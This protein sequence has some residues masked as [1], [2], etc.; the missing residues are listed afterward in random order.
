MKRPSL[1]NRLAL[2]VVVGATLALVLRAVRGR[3]LAQAPSV[4]APSTEWPP[5]PDLAAPRT[6]TTPP[7]RTT[8]ASPVVTASPIATTPITTTAPAPAPPDATVPPA[9]MAPVVI[10]PPDPD[11]DPDRGPDPAP[12]TVPAATTDEPTPP[13]VRVPGD[14]PGG[15]AG[16]LVTDP[17]PEAVLPD[18]RIDRARD[19]RPVMSRGV[20][21]DVPPAPEPTFGTAPDAEAAAEASVPVATPVER[22][23]EEVLEVPQ[24]A[25]PE[26]PPEGG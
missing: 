8:P 26:R 24:R 25:T 3:R 10:S 12:V 7:V 4:P 9:P 13:A 1:W 23:P 17:E 11:P 19:E 16:T 21:G 6:A 5:L 18:E 22:E 2:S 15:A 14:G 20:E